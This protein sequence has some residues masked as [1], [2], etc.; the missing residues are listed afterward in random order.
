[1][2]SEESDGTESIDLCSPSS[3]AR[4]PHYKVPAVPTSPSLYLRTHLAY[5]SH[6][7]ASAQQLNL[8]PLRRWDNVDAVALVRLEIEALTQDAAD[9][10][11]RNRAI[12]FGSVPLN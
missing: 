10:S 11:V 6:A 5:D 1:M 2:K 7:I 4:E 12:V 9:P 3:D 8:R